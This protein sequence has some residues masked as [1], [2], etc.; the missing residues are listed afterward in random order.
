MLDTEEMLNDHLAHHLSRAHHCKVCRKAF[1]NR[2]TL[3]VHMKTHK[4][5]LNYQ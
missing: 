3:T 2:T 1:I 4:D 5:K